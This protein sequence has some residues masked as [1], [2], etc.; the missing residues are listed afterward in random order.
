MNSV[1]PAS[2]AHF[3]MT[4]HHQADTISPALVFIA[5]PN[6][7]TANRLDDGNLEIICTHAP[8]LVVL[9]EAYYRFAGNSRVSEV[10]DIENLVVLQ[11]MKSK[12]LTDHHTHSKN[13]YNISFITRYK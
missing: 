3:A 9:D 7:P 13:P 1:S 6:N 11:T 4:L 10:A 5:S 2:H 8:G 12:H